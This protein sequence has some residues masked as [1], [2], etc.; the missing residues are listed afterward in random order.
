MRIM[1]ELPKQDNPFTSNGSAILCKI[2]EQA[3]IDRLRDEFLSRGGKIDYCGKA[4][5]IF[6]EP[7][8]KPATSPA[9]RNTIRKGTGDLSPITLIPYKNRATTISKWG[10]NIR[11]YP[12]GLT[13]WVQVATIELGRGLGWDHATAIK[14]RDKYRAANN[15]PPA[16]Y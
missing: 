9:K 7:E 4:P 5:D 11:A 1:E 16:D 13:F 10:Q 8:V 3:E 12:D 6:I 2:S 15:L 14:E